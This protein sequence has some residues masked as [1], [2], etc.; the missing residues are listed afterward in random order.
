MRDE[1]G[2]VASRQGGGGPFKVG[3]N[4]IA[5]MVKQVN[6]TSSD[7]SFDLQ[8]QMGDQSL[9]GLWAANPAGAMY[10]PAWAR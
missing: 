7:T 5:V 1:G 2:G 3:Q 9:A 10:T 4:V 6:G 8:L